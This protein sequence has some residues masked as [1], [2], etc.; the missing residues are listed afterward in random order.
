SATGTVLGL[1]LVMILGFEGLFLPA[2]ILAAVAAGTVWMAAGA[3]LELGSIRV[4]GV[5]FTAALL[6]M[7]VDYGI[8]GANRFRD[9]RLRGEGVA[10]RLAAPSRETARGVAPTAVTTA[11]GLAALSVAHFRLLRELG[12][13]LSLGVIATLVATATLG[14]AVLAGFPAASARSRPLRLCPR[15][16]RPALAG[17]AAL[18]SR[19]W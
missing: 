1:A 17:L 11:A 5:G 9:L 3:A 15:V 6:G 13:V 4:P 10:A 12:A 2:A 18:S 16:G 14:A 8:L 7:G 19:R